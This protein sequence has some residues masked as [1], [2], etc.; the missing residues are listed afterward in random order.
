MI[1]EMKRD[2]VSDSLLDAAEDL[3]EQW[4]EI[5]TAIADRLVD[6]RSH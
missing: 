4:S 1:E 5:A 3:D 6:M 2:E